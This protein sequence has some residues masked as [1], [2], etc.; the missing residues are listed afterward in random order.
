MKKTIPSI[1]IP[2]VVF[3]L[4]TTLLLQ[5]DIFV[6][7]PRAQVVQFSCR[8]Q[9]ENN[10]TVFVPNFIASMQKISEQMRT[11]RFGVAVT[12]SGPDADYGLGQCYGD[13]SLSDCVLCYAEARSVLPQCF[14]YNS[15]RIYLDGCFLRSENYSYFEEYTGPE[16]RA[17]CGNTTQKDSAF[18]KS[19]RQAV[20]QAASDA[21]NNNGYAR[22]RVPVSGTANESAYVLSD[23]WRTLDVSSCRACLQNA[24]N[25]ILGCLPWSE[26]RALNTGCFMRYS[27]T[28]FLNPEPQNGS[29]RGTIIVV[30]VAVVSSVVVLVAGAVIGFYIWKHREIQKKRRGSNDAEK[31]AKTLDDSSLNFKYS[32]L[33]KATGSFDNANKLGQGGFGMVYKLVNHDWKQ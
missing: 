11:T 4:T 28:N 23:C 32:T 29:S 15:G 10:S 19:A 13:L 27:D 30:V 31:L 7:E 21:P 3:V 18:Q 9:L 20:L 1:P 12:G 14:P 24:S 8:N 26:G 5:L 22:V 17:L 16:D 6:A 33:E 2:S 25:S